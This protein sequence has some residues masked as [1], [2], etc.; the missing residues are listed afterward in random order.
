M[1]RQISSLLR[2]VSTCYII[3]AISLGADEISDILSEICSKKPIEV[4]TADIP[5][6]LR[7]AVY[8]AL[9]EDGSGYLLRLGHRPS[10]EN[11][12]QV[13]ADTEG[14]SRIARQKLKTSAS[15]YVV[16]H[17]ES[18]L[19]K[20][21]KPERRL[22]TSGATAD[23][24]LGISHTT[25]KIIL[26]ILSDAPEI[27]ARVRNWASSGSVKSPE[28]LLDHVRNWW[29]SN[30]KALSSNAWLDLKPYPLLDPIDVRAESDPR[31]LPPPL[32]IRGS[33]HL[34]QKGEL[35]SIRSLTYVFPIFGL[36]F[37]IALLKRFYMR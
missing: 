36:I 25:A 12:T 9:K 24:D 32:P 16:H 21:E 15:P 30:E 7:T 3:S 1:S 37:V 20:D 17:L 13:F 23:H 5:A 6:E 28:D 19:F 2:L 8:S 18:F 35:Q 10:I 34:A 26:Q 29:H 4:S 14:K 33:V 11:L 27:P 22:W 31:P